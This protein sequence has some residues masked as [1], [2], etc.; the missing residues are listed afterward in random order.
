MKE[1]T[2]HMWLQSAR[3]HPGTPQFRE[4]PESLPGSLEGRGIAAFGCVGVGCCGFGLDFDILRGL[5]LALDIFGPGLAFDLDIGL[6]PPPDL[7]CPEM[8]LPPG[9]LRPEVSV[10]FNV[11]LGPPGLA[12]VPE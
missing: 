3:L 10:I 8:A 11:L 6:E 9:I 2:L 4:N 1:L 7:L 12:V 5:V